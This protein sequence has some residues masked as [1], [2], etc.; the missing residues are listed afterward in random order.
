MTDAA[1]SRA[2]QPL[3]T[4]RQRS[5]W[6]GPEPSLQHVQLSVLAARMQASSSCR[7]LQDLRSAI[8]AER[9]HALQL[10]ALSEGL[11]CGDGA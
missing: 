9:Q 3:T 10:A 8:S 2:Q 11:T 6:Q 1:S 7:M 5:R 4:A